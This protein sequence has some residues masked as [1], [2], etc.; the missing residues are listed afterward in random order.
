MPETP[1][2]QTRDVD[3]RRMKAA[4]LAVAA[5]LFAA[6]PLAVPFQGFDPELFPIPQDDPPVQPAGYAFAIWGPI[7]L[8]LLVSAGVGLVRRAE[9][10]DWDAPRW[11][12]IGSLVI[13]AAWLGIAQA[14]AIW[15]TV[16]IWAMLLLA[17]MALFRTPARDP[18]LLRGPV[19]LYAG[20]LTAASWVSVGL[21]G[22]GYGIG[23][24][25]TGWAILALFGALATAVT[26]QLRIGRAPFY[27]AA[28]IWALI[29]V[30]VAN[31]G[32]ASGVAL[33]AAAGALA[34]AAATLRGL[35]GT[36]AE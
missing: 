1:E 27:G 33:L 35:R 32:T 30:A 24:G 15:A 20:W 2:T 12:L 3:H 16:L 6:A 18:W 9:A 14:S 5:L 26:V 19:A 13:G 21:L 31:T 25:A 7:Y 17:L 36:G 4:L 22:A 34:M 10:P 11:P 23:P 29:G 28:A 8:W